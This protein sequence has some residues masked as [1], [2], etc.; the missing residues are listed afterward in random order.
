M[1]ARGGSTSPR[2]KISSVRILTLREGRY[3]SPVDK[4]STGKA[5]L[6][7]QLQVWQNLR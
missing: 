2:E 6:I 1:L 4:V 5:H 3:T 7:W